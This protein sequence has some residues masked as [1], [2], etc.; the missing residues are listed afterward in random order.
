MDF[1]ARFTG[2][3]DFTNNRLDAFRRTSLVF[4]INQAIDELAYIWIAVL[5][6]FPEIVKRTLKLLNDIR[7]AFKLSG[8]YRGK[9]IVQVTRNASNCVFVLADALLNIKCQYL[10]AFGAILLRTG[11]RLP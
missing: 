7:S 9:L 6:A 1:L 8:W 11:C 10:A 2:I 4:D 5:D 3:D